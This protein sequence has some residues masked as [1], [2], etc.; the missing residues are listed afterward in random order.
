[1]TEASAAAPVSPATSAPS[2][3][4]KVCFAVSLACTS[5]AVLGGF[6][7]HGAVWSPAAQLWAWALYTVAVAAFYFATYGQI[8]PERL[9][10]WRAA[11]AV[12]A[13]ACAGIVVFAY[14]SPAEVPL[15]MVFGHA[16]AAVMLGAWAAWPHWVGWAGSPRRR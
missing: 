13:A 15:M 12:V 4:S 10:R 1:M 8:R 3:T 6:P 2:T 14:A 7:G 11:A 16:V 9:T 5:L